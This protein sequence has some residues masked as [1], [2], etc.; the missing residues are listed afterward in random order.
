MEAVQERK[1][2]LRMRATVP[3]CLGFAM[4]KNGLPLVEELLVENLG[5]APL[6]GA[7]L[8]MEFSEAF[9]SF[10][11]LGIDRLEPG[12]SL[13]LRSLPLR[14]DAGCL[15]QCTEGQEAWVDFVLEKQG[16]VL[17][18]ETASFPPARL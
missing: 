3:P 4:A 14:L 12:Q 8:R 10:D 6:E 15:A 2:E 1:A 7:R 5:E 9:A 16:R 18:K 13:S 17:A 11:G